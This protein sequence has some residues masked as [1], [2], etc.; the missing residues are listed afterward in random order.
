MYRA[1]TTTQSDDNEEAPCWYAVRTRSR[2]EA[3][4]SVALS[5]KEFEVFYPAIYVLSRWKD[6][7]KKIKKPLF[8]GYTFVRCV[9]GYEPRLAI[10]KVF[11]VVN[12][13]GN[14]SNCAVPIPDEQ[15]DTV[16]RLVDSGYTP[17]PHP[18]LNK[19]DKVVVKE[20]SMLGATGYF[21]DAGKE[22]GRLIVS[23]DML[24]RSLEV[25]IDAHM[26]ERF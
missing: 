9:M 3:K 19:G 23:V 15:I 1:M 12:I 7:K 18:Y 16:K 26:V 2:H 21:V 8:S 11:G 10:L 20:G 25:D 24:G 17:R 4:V 5:E 14:A 22:T 13:L 6:R